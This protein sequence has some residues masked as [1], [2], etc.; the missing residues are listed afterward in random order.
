MAKKKTIT[1]RRIVRLLNDLL[2][3]DR[4]AMYFLTCA[5]APANQKLIDHPSVVVAEP[6]R[7]QHVLRWL[8]VLQA[9]GVMDGHEIQAVYQTDK[10][11][12]CRRLLRFIAVKCRPRH[13][14]FPDQKKAVKKPVAPRVG[15]GV[16][17]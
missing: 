10:T 14:R 16:G 3:A 7:G 2:V 4:Q 5:M 12:T 13:I 9:I 6:V 11:G 17:R 1:S 15:K 8:G